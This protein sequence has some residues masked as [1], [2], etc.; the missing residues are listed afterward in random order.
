MRMEYQWDF[1][2][3]VRRLFLSLI[4]LAALIYI[5]SIARFTY[6]MPYG[7]DYDAVLGFLNQYWAADSWQRFILLFSQHNEHRVLLTHLFEVVD[8]QLFGQVNFTHLIWLGNLGWFLVIYT[9]WS[10]AK[11]QAI[12]MIAFGPVIILLFSFSHY[13]MMTW[14]MTS[15]QQYYQI[16]FSILSLRFMVRHQWMAFTPFFLLAV[17]TG[18]GGLILI[19]VFVFYLLWNK[20][21]R[22]VAPFL[23]LFVTT[24]YIYFSFL[25]YVNLTPTAKFMGAL[26]HPL[27]LATFAVGFIGG[28]GNVQIV[29]LASFVSVGLL[30]L[31]LFASQARFLF[32][33]DPFLAWM[34]VYIGLT[35][36]LAALNRLDIGVQA[37]GDSRYSTYSLVFCACLYLSAL[38]RFSTMN[39]QKK[40]VGWGYVFATLLFIA[41]YFQAFTALNDRL[42]WL[43]NGFA[44]YPDLVRARAVLDQ[45]HELGIFLVPN[46]LY[47]RREK[48]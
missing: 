19:P 17:F 29:G 45:S 9:M 1:S 40:I 37:G 7:D 18:G 42:Y 16:L 20:S 35:A 48:K 31:V 15:I 22:L 26:S 30:F 3:L 25:P 10:Y 27:D 24:L 5:G 36:G 11:S 38:L 6:N 14:A 12:P 46:E 8:W 39:M 28:V 13:E 33:E 23:A 4:W 47:K 43:K 21:Y 34:G 32:K 2:P 44:T 41:W